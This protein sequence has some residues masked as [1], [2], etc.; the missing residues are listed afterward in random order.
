MAGFHDLMKVEMNASRTTI[1][2]PAGKRTTNPRHYRPNL[3]VPTWFE[4]LKLNTAK[5]S[6]RAIFNMPKIKTNRPDVSN[7]LL[8]LTAVHRTGTDSSTL[9]YSRCSYQ[10]S[11]T[12]SD[13]RAPGQQDHRNCTICPSVC[14][15]V[16]NGDR[17]DGF[18]WTLYF[19]VVWL[20]VICK[21][22]FS[23]DNTTTTTTRNIWKACFRACCP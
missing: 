2:A 22:G 20:N 14:R 16:P 4:N 12:S 5:C 6:D 21:M 1:L 8:T 10:G 17:L 9:K 23:F 11:I 7:V 19:S 3:Y 15:Q 13:I 18:S